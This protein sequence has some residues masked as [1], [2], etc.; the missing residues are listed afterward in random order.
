MSERLLFVLAERH[1][2]GFVTLRVAMSFELSVGIIVAGV[3]NFHRKVLD[4]CPQAF[5]N[6]PSLGLMRHF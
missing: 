6:I 4:L 5:K 2:Q 1:I 3:A